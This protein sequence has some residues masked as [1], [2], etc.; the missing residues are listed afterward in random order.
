MRL[1]GECDEAWKSF[2]EL[3]GEHLRW[4]QTAPW[5]SQ[6]SEIAT[7]D[8]RVLAIVEGVRLFPIPGNMPRP[9]RRVT[10]GQVTYQVTGRVFGARVTAPDG[11][12]ILSFT[13]TKHFARQARAVAHMS[14]GRS[15]RFPVQ[16]T[17][18]SNAVMTATDDAGSPVFR[19]RRVRNAGPGG[20]RK[21]AVEILV[22]PGRQTTPE[23]LLI[24]ATGY[25]NLST[26]FDRSA[27]G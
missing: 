5:L 26:F 23:M 7:Q 16:G 11:V 12:I 17:S 21:K 13:G 2:P 24:M 1:K 19:L 6:R 14:D 9:P 25:Y 22:E 18:K 27:G 10:I 8:G 3:P 15:V 20:H 4:H